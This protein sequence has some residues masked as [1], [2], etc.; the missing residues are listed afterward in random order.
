MAEFLN[1]MSEDERR[2]VWGGVDG[3]TIAP[4]AFPRAWLTLV[5]DGKGERDWFP[6]QLNW[7]GTPFGGQVSVE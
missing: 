2:Q 6:Y 7:S 1:R 4:A 3:Q 5:N